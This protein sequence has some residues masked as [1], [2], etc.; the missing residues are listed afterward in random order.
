MSRWRNVRQRYIHTHVVNLLL[1][2]FFFLCSYTIILLP[3][4]SVISLIKNRIVYFSNLNPIRVIDEYMNEYN[5]MILFFWF[6]VVKN[7]T[8]FGFVSFFPRFT[9]K[10]NQSLVNTLFKFLI[11]QITIYNSVILTIKL[12]IIIYKPVFSG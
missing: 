9:I 4:P 3:V 5:G 6:I 10:Y 12:K 7:H 2:F 11:Y 8:I 1:I